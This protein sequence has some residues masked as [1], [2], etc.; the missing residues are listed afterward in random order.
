ML[1]LHTVLVVNQSEGRNGLLDSLRVCGWN[2]PFCWLVEWTV[3]E[4]VGCDRPVLLLL[5]V[6]RRLAGG[7]E[8][9][10]LGRLEG[11]NLQ[12]AVSRDPVIS[13][14]SR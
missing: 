13:L 1:V 6:A 3:L 4:G 8:A 10:K 14:T 12:T 5:V 7:L 2:G 9:W 11:W